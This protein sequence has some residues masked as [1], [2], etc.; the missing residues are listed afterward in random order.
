MELLNSTI[1][2][3]QLIHQGKVRDIYDIDQSKMLIITTD[4]LSAFDVILGEPIPY[5]GEVLTQM[6]NFWFDYFKEVPN[7]LTHDNPEDYV[8][9]EEI[10]QV[11]GRAV[12][13]KK[14]RPIP[15]EAIVRGYII[16]SGWKEY[17]KNQTICGID[18]PAQL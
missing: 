11:I 17:Q 14:L 7:H 12:V 15:I 8:L 6:A 1:K 3:L 9:P 2:S 10:D 18:L 5:K 16:G 4:R 13:V